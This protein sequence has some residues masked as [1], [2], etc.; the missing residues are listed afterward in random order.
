[1]H[2]AYVAAKPSTSQILTS[3]HH[4]FAHHNI[5]WYRQLLLHLFLLAHVLEDCRQ[6]E[7][8]VYMKIGRWQGEIPTWGKVVED[9]LKALLLNIPILLADFASK[10]MYIPW[11]S[12]YSYKSVL[13]SQ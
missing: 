7:R 6:E 3:T 10:R 12:A 4:V 9:E 5:Q 11:S 2:G 8:E 13:A 1:M